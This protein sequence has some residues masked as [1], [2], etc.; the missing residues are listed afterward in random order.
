MLYT[1]MPSYNIGNGG[2]EMKRKVHRNLGTVQTKTKA[3]NVTHWGHQ[4][5]RK[6]LFLTFSLPHHAYG[7]GSASRY[8]LRAVIE[9]PYAIDAS[10]M[11]YCGIRKPPC[12][13]CSSIAHAT[14]RLPSLNSFCARVSQVCCGQRLLLAA[15]SKG[16]APVPSWFREERACGSFGTWGRCP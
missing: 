16:Y 8:Q 9:S 14:S 11:T 4:G 6:W 3:S 2:N 13:S 15:G 1:L 5:G 10:K 7:E 12:R